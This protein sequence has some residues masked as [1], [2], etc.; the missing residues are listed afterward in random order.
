MKK[1]LL[2]ILAQCGLLISSS[3]AQVIEWQKCFGGSSQDN[4]TRLYPTADGCFLLIGTTYSNDG[5]VTG[6]HGNTDIWLVKINASGNILWQKC[7]GGTDAEGS[8]SV[9][10]TSD[11]G[12]VLTGNSWSVDGDATANY[13][14]M[15]TWVVKIDSAGTLQWQKNYG[16]SNDEIGNEIFQTSDG[17]Y[18]FTG[19]S[20]SAD[21]DVSVHFGLP[22][23]PDIWCAR[24]DSA[25]N[26]LWDKSLGG[27]G[28]EYSWSAVQAD[29]GGFVVCGYSF[30]FNLP[31]FHGQ[32]DILIS[33]L[34]TA[35][36]IQWQN[37]LGGSVYDWATHIIKCND[38]GYAVF[39]STNSNNMDVTGNHG[40]WDGWVVRLDSAGNIIWQ[41]T[42]GG[43]GF[44]QLQNGFQTSDGGFLVVGRSSSADSLVPLNRGQK[45]YFVCKLDSSGTPLWQ[46]TFGGEYDDLAASVIT[47]H[48][49]KIMVGG[50]THSNNI[51][52]SGNHSSLDCWILK[53]TDNY[54]LVTG[55]AYID[56]NSNNQADST[57]APVSTY[58]I[59]ES[60]TARNAY[61]YS[62]GMYELSVLD[63][64]NFI[65]TTAP[66]NYYNPAPA[67][68]SVYF[69]GIN[70]EDS[71]NDFAFQPAGVYNDLAVT[72]TPVYGFEPGFNC[73]Y[74]ISYKNVG[75]TI[76]NGNIVFQHSQYLIFDSASLAPSYLSP[77]SAIWNFAS[78]SP[79]WQ[80]GI[81]IYM[82]VDVAA[83]AGATIL[84]SAT[85][86]PVAGDAN[87]ADNYSSCNNTITSSYDPNDKTVNRDT[88]YTTELSNPPFLDYTIRFQNTGTD[89]AFTIKIADNIIQKLN[90]GSFEFAASSHPVQI[91]Y[92]A[93]SR[94]LEFDYNN[95]ILPDSGANEP[96]SH[97]FVRFRIKPNS[98]VTAGS[99][100]WNKAAIYFDYNQPV[101]TK[102]ALTE[103]V[104]PVGIG[105]PAATGSL[106]K[107]FPSP[108]TDQ[109]TIQSLQPL[110]G[111]TDLSIL[112]LF[113]RELF[114]LHIP[115]LH[116]QTTIDI[117]GFSK[118]IYF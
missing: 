105:E 15:D 98:T 71:L 85:I 50:I 60:N 6:N 56:L 46:K 97:G 2:L 77:D 100:V 22:G 20:R 91:T 116:A 17:G 83:P 76:L 117:S 8:G 66:F 63:S 112:D 36:N 73:G 24:L 101:W 10:S 68:H 54:N 59:V 96:A 5:D 51:D 89:T 49:N 58:K 109:I 30:S 88:I 23:D 57:D 78:L 118:G 99:N 113:G 72:L 43:T 111:N 82:H 19:D 41:K 32:E 102:P 74:H 44:D 61:T 11:G 28:I 86:E 31:N 7:Y 33:K 40:D 55:N 12:Y 65:A 75:T 25:G 53:L 9:S 94:L 79:Y 106:F 4:F 35:G 110:T 95:I 47:I 26:I 45:D 93:S 37:C 52:V 70:Q 81:I 16:G 90:M 34:D 3:P 18:F 103:I 114:T 14:L 69:P 104:M 29:D 67:S 21:H 87:A 1:L 39:G 27:T 38:G 107:F 62:S 13:G 80:Q 42:L 115:E 48:D 84:S 108:A 92:H 64:G